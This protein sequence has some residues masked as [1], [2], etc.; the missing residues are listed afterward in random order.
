MEK[1]SQI[2][3]PIENLNSCKDQSKN[4]VSE[5]EDKVEE[6]ISSVKSKL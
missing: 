3:I 6:I 4:K 1:I 2:K 5:L